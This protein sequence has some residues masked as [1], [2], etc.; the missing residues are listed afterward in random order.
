MNSSIPYW[1]DTVT[2][3]NKLSGRDSITKLDTWKKTV[4]HGCFYKQVVQHDI[5][6]TTVSV[7]TSSV[8]RIPKNQEYKPYHEWREDISDGFTISVGDYIF[9]G[10]LTEDVNADN[11]VSLYN[12]YKPNAMLVRSVSDNSDFMGLCEHYRVEGV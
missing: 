4:L 6:G 9:I 2:I 1:N 10:E 3:C 12:S 11:I 8:C 5:N 7:G